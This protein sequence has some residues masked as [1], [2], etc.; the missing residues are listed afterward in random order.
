M[1]RVLSS[2]HLASPRRRHR[3]ARTVLAAALA[4]TTA[5]A[6]APP[7]AAH[8][9][10]TIPA[11]PPANSSPQADAKKITLSNAREVTANLWEWNW[12]S[13]ANECTTVLGPKGYG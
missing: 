11:T 10:P 5:G 8:S 3:L 13:I 1:T 9:A 6:L 7:P 4:G 2:R 12:P